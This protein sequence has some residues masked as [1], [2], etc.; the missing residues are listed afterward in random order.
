MQYHRFVL[1]LF[2]KEANAWTLVHTIQIKSAKQSSTDI[3]QN[4]PNYVRFDA[5][6]KMAE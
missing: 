4:N 2:L 3:I 6:F 1:D 5:D